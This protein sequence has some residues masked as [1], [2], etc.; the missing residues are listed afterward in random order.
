MKLVLVL[1]PVAL[2]NH[3]SLVSYLREKE[4]QPVLC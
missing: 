2:S 4:S 3:E 1:S